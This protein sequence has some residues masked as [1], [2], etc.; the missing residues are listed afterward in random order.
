MELPLYEY[1]TNAQKKKGSD[2][3]DYFLSQGI[4]P[5]TNGKLVQI[6]YSITVVP[7]YNTCCVCS[8]PQTQVSCFISPPQLPSYQPIQAPAGWNP[9]V[10]DTKNLALPVDPAAPVYPAI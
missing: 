3:D 4:Q 2:E 7:E 9:Q 6:S 1:K 8:P 5:S 10:F